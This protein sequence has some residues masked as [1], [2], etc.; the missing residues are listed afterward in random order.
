MTYGR[1]EDLKFAVEVFDENGNL[2][3]V[4][5]RLRDLD[6]AR[7]AYETCRTKIR[8]S[9]CTYDTVQTMPMWDK[10]PQTNSRLL[11]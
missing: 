11:P 7:A 10:N 5:A 2:I 3:E 6:A 4:L 8:R 1:I 9:C